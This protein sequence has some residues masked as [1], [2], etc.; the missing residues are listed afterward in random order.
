MAKVN[1]SVIEKIDRFL[2][3]FLQGGIHVE[4]AYLYGSY[5]RGQENE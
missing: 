1:A 2:N 5:A 3:R 4:K